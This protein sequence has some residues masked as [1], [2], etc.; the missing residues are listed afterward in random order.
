MEHLEALPLPSLKEE[1]KLKAAVYDFICLRQPELYIWTTRE[2]VDYVDKTLKYY[3]SDA[4]TV[5][6]NLELSVIP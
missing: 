6:E 5:I 2:I 4:K 1:L 3:G